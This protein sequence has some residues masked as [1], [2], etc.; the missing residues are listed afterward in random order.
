MQD[1]GHTQDQEHIQDKAED[2]PCRGK[3]E[4]IVATSYEELKQSLL[5]DK[6][7]SSSNDP[8]LLHEQEL[9][10]FKSVEKCLEDVRAATG[11]S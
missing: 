3:W 10:I 1:H 5:E 2:F 4:S 9:G 11:M 8:C 7:T 6:S